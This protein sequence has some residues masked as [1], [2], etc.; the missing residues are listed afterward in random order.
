MTLERSIEVDLRVN[1][2]IEDAMWIEPKF[3]KLTTGN[4]DD[5]RTI[6]SD[7]GKTLGVIVREIDW[8]D[9]GTRSVSYKPKITGYRVEFWRDPNPDHYERDV[10]IADE[11]FEVLAD[12][13]AEAKRIYARY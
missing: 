6:Y 8:I 2:R 9:V 13:V 5:G 12:A 1:G 11:V 7:G 10:T 4:D 3:P